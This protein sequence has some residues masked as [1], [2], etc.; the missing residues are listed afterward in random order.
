MQPSTDTG[1]RDVWSWALS[2]LTRP[3]AD[4]QKRAKQMTLVEGLTTR[5]RDLDT[6]AGLHERYCRDS[7]WCLL[8]AEELFPR[9]WPTLGVHACTGAAYGLRYVELMTARRLDATAPLPTWV[10]EWAIWT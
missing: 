6:V 2:W 1:M 5:L 9:D 4:A 7:R 10:G 3:P 8:T